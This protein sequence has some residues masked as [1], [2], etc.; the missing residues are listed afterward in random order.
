MRTGLIFACLLSVVCLPGEAHGFLFR[1]R[2]RRCCCKTVASTTEIYT[3]APATE[4]EQQLF[5]RDRVLALLARKGVPRTVLPKG[6]VRPR[7]VNAELIAF[8]WSLIQND[9]ETLLQKELQ[10]DYKPQL[11]LVHKVVDQRTGAYRFILPKPADE[12]LTA[13]L[14]DI[15]SLDDEAF[16]VR[17][18]LV[19]ERLPVRAQD[20]K[21]EL[22]ANQ[23]PNLV[24]IQQTLINLLQ[25][26]AEL[27]SEAQKV[28][29]A[30]KP[31]KVPNELT[32]DSLLVV[33]QWQDIVHEKDFRLYWRVHIDVARQPHGNWE[34]G[35]AIDFGERLSSQAPSQ[36]HKIAD[37]NNLGVFDA[38]RRGPVPGNPN[39][40]LNEVTY[41][42]VTL[43]GER[44]LQS[45]D[46][47]V[48]SEM[49]PL[50]WNKVKDAILIRMRTQP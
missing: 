50:L 41:K 44:I 4:A 11:F 25:S 3:S 7:D 27:R 9:L 39:A 23:E 37:T 36:I 5:P 48:F 30:I 33:T 35:T 8:S 32:R 20:F 22:T 28:E 45:K 42:P 12:R 6:V 47:E 31:I 14:Q 10:L 43:A 18:R 15:F 17:I 40:I 13:L 46:I 16:D 26:D 2:S 1:R 24:S 38:N 21:P 29:G 34:V 19:G 49:A